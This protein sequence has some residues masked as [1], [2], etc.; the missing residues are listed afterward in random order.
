MATIV[1]RAGKGTPLT[2]AEADANF[3]NLN[4]DIALKAPLASPAL[5]GTPTAPTAAQGTNTTQL[6]TMAAL[7]TGL[8]AKLDTTGGSL[9]GAL[10]EART[11]LA[12]NATTTDIWTGQGG[13]INLTGTPTYTNFAAAPQAG[14][15]RRLYPATGAV[16]ANGGAFGMVGNANYTV[17]AG[18]S[19]DVEAITTT[20]F[21]LM[22]LNADGTP[23]APSAQ[24]TET[25]RG[26]AQVATQAETDAGSI[27]TDM[28]TPLKLRNGFASSLTTNG[29][30]KLPSWLLGLIFQWGQIPSA[31]YANATN[32][33]LT[34]THPIAFPVAVGWSCL[35][36]G[37]KNNGANVTLSGTTT[38]TGIDANYN[39]SSSITLTV[40]F[41]WF[42][43]GW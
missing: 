22:P 2:N 39:N 13:S 7:F 38:L 10:N 29:Y 17:P 11:T 3:T 9:T 40:M 16:F 36:Q 33:T 43:I 4:S 18:G 34:V 26:T 30:I 14:A 23:I 12:G 15:K 31:S 6:A 28:V 35:F 19:V 41:R 24:A 27:D 32:T 5:T 21:R 25:V 37:T 8:A 42:S 20:T 1:T